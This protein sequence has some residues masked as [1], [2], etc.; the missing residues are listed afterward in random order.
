MEDNFAVHYSKTKR[1]VTAGCSE[2]ASGQ[3]FWTEGVDLSPQDYKM[4]LMRSALLRP[5]AHQHFR[6]TLV[7]TVLRA[8]LTTGLVPGSVVEYFG[9]AGKRVLGL[10]VVCLLVSCAIVEVNTVLRL[11][12]MTS[13]FKLW[14]MM[15]A[16][17]W[18]HAVGLLFLAVHRR[19]FR[20]L[21]I[22]LFLKQQR[23]RSFRKKVNR[24]VFMC[25]FYCFSREFRRW[26]R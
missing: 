21:P 9:Q 24:Y 23:K 17:K 19:Q 6:K 11:A 13:K 5:R 15:V 3:S 22:S 20:A 10:V 16:P 18:Y 2:L 14:T 8:S 25:L 12:K 7:Q 26:T 1:R 4:S